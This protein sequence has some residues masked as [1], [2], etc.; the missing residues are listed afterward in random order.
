M[1]ET[2]SE[3]F[4]KLNFAF[5]FKLLDERHEEGFEFVL[6][7]LVFIFV[8]LMAKSKKLNN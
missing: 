2:D 7:F 4:D 1:S 5:N 8:L 3:E 6:Y